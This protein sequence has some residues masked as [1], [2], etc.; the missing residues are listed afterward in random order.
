MTGNSS[1][2][3]WRLK[4][5][6]PKLE[7][8]KHLLLK[9]YFDE[10]A[11]FNRK[12]NLVS[13]KSLSSADSTHFA[14]SVF[15]SDIVYK[16][17]NDIKSLADIGSGNGFPGL[18]F[19]ST[20]VDIKVQLLD[21]DQRKIEFLK[22]VISKLGLKNVVAKVQDAGRIEADSLDAVVTRGFATIDKSISMFGEAVKQRG[23]IF[24]LK[25]SDYQVELDGM[26][27]ANAAKW[28]VEIKGSYK[29]PAS[30]AEMFVLG[31]SRKD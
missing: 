20:H 12:I 6:F 26:C 16:N 30:E 9:V 21:L 29:L 7:D 3:S 25:S 13:P 5:W 24:F 15:A 14:D 11:K 23:S 19:A 22:H 31:A 17:M 8:E 4:S 2:Y 28:T 18:V 27:A 10:L 1:E